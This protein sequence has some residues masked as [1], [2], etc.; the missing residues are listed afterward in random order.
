M[1]TTPR[2]A[3]VAREEV[4]TIDERYAGYQE[5]LVAAL[6]SLI[7]RQSHATDRQR[8]DQLHKVIDGIGRRAIALGRKGA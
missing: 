5:D 3:E 4:A 2:I 7:Q 8:Q 6:S 1:T